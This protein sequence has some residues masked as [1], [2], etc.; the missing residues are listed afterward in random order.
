MRDIEAL[1]PVVGKELL[2]TPQSSHG[3]PPA[4]RDT[5]GEVFFKSDAAVQTPSDKVAF[6]GES[7]AYAEQALVRAFGEEVP[8]LASSSFRAVFDAVLDG[9]AGFGVVPVENSLAGSIHENYDLFLRYPDIAMVGELKLRIVHCLIGDEKAT[10]E[11]IGIV[12]S[13]PQGFAQCREFLD[14]HPDW[15][16]EACNDTATAVASIAREGATKVAAI[17]GEPAAKAHG[18]RVLKTGIETNPLNYTR[19]AIIAR[20]N[21][22]AAVLGG[23]DNAPVPPSLGSG[24]PNKA[25]LVFSVSDEPGS[26]FACLRIMS[27]R[28][29]NLSKLESRPIQGKPWEYLFYV[30]VTLPE[31]EGIFDELLGELK[32]K[33]RDFHFLGSYRASL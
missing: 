16:L 24:P 11:K 18:L 23:N 15:Q 19:F 10:I 12:R 14:K 26:L 7:G 29:I 3:R 33:T 20:R 1:A 21:G 28:G 17:A 8:R 31:G 6:S 4:V 2:R 5:I 27:E 32:T 13:H 22:N 30:D 9:S 25:S